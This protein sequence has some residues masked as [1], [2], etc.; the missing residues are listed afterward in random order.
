M[1]EFLGIFSGVRFPHHIGDRITRDEV[2]HQKDN[3][4]HTEQC[5][6][7]EQ[8]A[9][10]EIFSHSVP[11]LGSVEDSLIIVTRPQPQ[12]ATQMERRNAPQTLTGLY[13]LREWQQSTGVWG[14]STCVCCISPPP[15]RS[16]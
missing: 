6:D 9:T 11:V 4:R 1:A 3:E 10:Q 13:P 2:H 8:Q 14:G 16:P 15:A 12:G 5:W 7:Q